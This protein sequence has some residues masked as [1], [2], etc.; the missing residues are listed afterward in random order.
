MNLTLPPYPNRLSIKTIDMHTGG[1]PLRVITGGYPVI[2]GANVLERRRYVEKNLDHL[3][4]S[5]MWE[6]RGHADM[7]GCLIVPPNDEGAAFGVI[8]MHNA[9]Y[10]SM[11]G[12][13]TIALGRLAK[14][15]KWVDTDVFHIDAP[16]G[17]LKITVS[18]D[19]VSF[20]G[21]PSFVLH[22]N[23]KINLIN[24]NSFEFDIA[25][26]GAFYA[27]VSVK[28]DM[29]PLTPDNYDKIKKLGGEIKQAIKNSGLSIDHP[30]E[31]DLSFLYGTIFIGGP[32]TDGVDSRNVCVFA[33]H[34]VDRCPTGSGVMGRMALHYAQGE[35]NKN[36]SMLIE[37][38][39]GTVFTGEVLE[40][41]NF[42]P[43]PAVIP[44]ITGNA[45]ITGEHTFLIDPSDPLR[46]GFLLS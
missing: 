5:L 3:R 24:G 22:K 46:N 25:Y 37:S 45:Y 21:V 9:G 14:I 11:C 41:T 33:D 2:E 4:T 38:I 15:L 35:L 7:Y 43:Y 18:E 6:P 34:E 26:G 12:H 29:L 17:R 16:C 23:R 31:P 44:K 39:L 30:F 1:E 42:G 8:F 10:S 40:E 28:E 13:A 32:I 19:N 20:I 36:E 27:Y